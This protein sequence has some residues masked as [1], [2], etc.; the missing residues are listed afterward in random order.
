LDSRLANS[1]L[2]INL[3][4]IVAVIIACATIIVRLS[5]RERA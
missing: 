2:L 4:G 5:M 3:V 1:Q